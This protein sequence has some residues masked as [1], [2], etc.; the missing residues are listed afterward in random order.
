LELF[1]TGKVKKKI[2]M[3]SKHHQMKDIV[4]IGGGP[5]GTAAAISAARFGVKVL[6]VEQQGYLGGM[7][8]GGLLSPILGGEINKG[9][10]LE[11]IKKLKKYD[12]I[13][14]PAYGRGQNPEYMKLVLE[15]MCQEAKVE[16]LYY[17]LGVGAL[18]EGNII[19]GIKIA[20]KSG[21]QEVKAR[22]VIDCSG[23]GDIAYRA[24]AKYEKGDKR[25]KLMPV[26][27]RF[28][29]GNIDIKKAIAF[30]RRYQQ[31]Y[32]G[33]IKCSNLTYPQIA[34]S[35]FESLIKKAKEKNEIHSADWAYAGFA[36]PGRPGEL[37]FNNPYVLNI[38]G[39]K[40]EDL[41]RAQIE[42]RR[43]VFEIARFFKKY[44]D[45]FQN[46]YIVAI[47]PLVGVRETRRIIGDYIITGKDI[48]QG[49]T[50]KDVIA[51]NTYMIDLHSSDGSR[52]DETDRKINLQYPSK[53]SEIPYRC[54]LPRG[55][56]NI[57][58]A[59]RCIS[60]TRDANSALRVTA[61]CFAIGQAAG[62]AAAIAVRRKITPREV[63]IKELQEN[64]R[65]QGVEI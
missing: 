30:T 27:L 57:L 7:L 56:E 25:G 52:K 4:I 9:F 3:D 16:L 60:S 14:E 48:L 44:I 31:E 64:L 17:T 20:S 5:S 53:P 45:G 50:F 23:D 18:T 32:P 39:T 28:I 59:G 40:P 37:V 26:T 15:E 12:A 41:T 13:F 61:N 29:L 42:G 38:D 43:F 19:K 34:L 49:T 33:D 63:D 54:L 8:T 2:N 10:Y 55:L 24:G 6:L 65:A 62:T 1:L 11:L 51:R 21:I 58:V 22:I 47:S 46:S 35:T 36:M